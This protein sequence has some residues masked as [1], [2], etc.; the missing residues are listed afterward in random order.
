[1]IISLFNS[2]YRTL[3]LSPLKLQVHINH[4]PIE[5]P[6]ADIAI[7]NGSRSGYSPL[8]Q[9][10]HDS[11]LRAKFTQR[12]SRGPGSTERASISSH[13]SLG[14]HSGGKS[15]QSKSANVS[16]IPR[17]GLPT[18]KNE[19]LNWVVREFLGKSVF[20]LFQITDFSLQS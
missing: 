4:L 2:T 19:L 20:L 10:L 9:F 6:W 8:Y 12:L 5:P 17:P 11:E 16:C 15:L 14:S 1:M 3:S 7:G 18:D 13:F